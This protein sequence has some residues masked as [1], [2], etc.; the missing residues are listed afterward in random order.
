MKPVLFKYYVTDLID[1]VVFG[2][3]SDDDA[4]LLAESEENFVVD[5]STGE[6]LLSDGTRQAIEPAGM[7]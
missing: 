4:G 1:G 7:G 5:S 2:T 6:W 3:N